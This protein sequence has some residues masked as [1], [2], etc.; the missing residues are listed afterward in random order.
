[1]PKI[2][3]ACFSISLDGYG[4]GPDQDIDNPLGIGGMA[5]HTWFFP[6]R[7]FQTMH[8]KG[9]GTTGIDD[10]FAKRGRTNFGA[11]ILGRN[12]FGPIRGPWKDENWKG[13]WGPSPPYHVPVFV[14]TR[15]PRPSIT[16][17]GGTTFHFIT[18]GIEAALRAA[19]TAAG[20]KDVGIGGGVA[21]VRQY[22]NARSIDE[23]HLA[24]SPVLLGRGEHLLSGLDLPKLGYRVTEH[25]PSASATHVILTKQ[26][27]M[28]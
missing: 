18:D 10:D 2:R 14:L 3:V 15:H 5:L 26:P 13:W 23:I 8:G 28:R 25:V 11:W 4:A 20:E 12:M 7:T 22:L 6:T 16:M 27:E 9:E 24:I 1:M 21:T 19:Q 17:E